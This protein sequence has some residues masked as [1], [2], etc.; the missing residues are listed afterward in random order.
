[1]SPKKRPLRKSTFPSL[2]SDAPAP[3]E[4][5]EE[6]TM[7]PSHEI[8]T[9]QRI[10]ADL[11]RKA[12]VGKITVAH[13]K[14]VKSLIDKHAFSGGAPLPFTDTARKHFANFLEKNRNMHAATSGSAATS[15]AV[16]PVSIFDS[17]GTD[18]TARMAL[19]LKN[20][21]T[22]PQTTGREEIIAALTTTLQRSGKGNAILTGDAGVGKSAIVEALALRTAKGELRG[23]L[24]RAR[25]VELA[26]CQLV[27]LVQEGSL[28]EKLRRLLKECAAI[29]NVILFIDE[30]HVVMK[31]PGMADFL[32][33]EIARGGVHLIGATTRREF[34]EMVRE[35]AALERRFAIIDVPE[36][37]E[38]ASIEALK[39]NVGRYEAHHGLRIEPEAIIEAV[40]MSA[41]YI[42]TRR[43][44]DKA[45]DVLDTAC[46]RN[47]LDG[48]DTVTVD[49]I[50][51][52]V[53]DL[54][55]IS[56][57]GR[58]DSRA[59]MRT[60]E[61]T[62][63]ERIIGQDEAISSVC[64]VF[65]LRETDMAPTNKPAS[66]L[67]A[68]PTGVGKTETAKATASAIFG[69][70][71]SFI[72]LDMTEYKNPSS[73][74][75]LI[76]AS[77]GLVGAE[78]GGLLTER[79]RTRPDSLILVDELDKANEDVQL[80]F[81]QLLEEGRL[82]DGRGETVNCANAVVV[83]TTNAGFTA[84]GAIGTKQAAMG[85]NSGP[86]TALDDPE[87]KARLFLKKFFPPEILNRFDNIVLFNQL[88]EQEMGGIA[89]LRIAEAVQAAEKRGYAVTV[90]EDVRNLVLERSDITHYGA[91]V[92]ARTV[93]KLVKLP[94]ARFMHSDDGVKE[95]R[96]ALSVTDKEMTVHA[97]NAPKP[98]PGRM[99]SQ[100]NP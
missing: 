60:L 58:E 2:R 18:L 7:I 82:T 16:T 90:G 56:L 33:P 78:R 35:D 74:S 36:L 75:R 68:G 38:E 83:M 99:T 27:T 98:P 72:T 86:K 52:C 34:R 77:V 54:T 45:F 55:H 93:R 53:S 84:E 1:M 63:R 40:R 49:D 69:D 6:N 19:K 80:V 48:R 5:M 44:P 25:I 12:G 79:L 31:I 37:S 26:S 21:E 42:T 50:R 47:V 43:L 3:P 65:A 100:G 81:M 13:I 23:R 51:N 46:S 71:D 24:N 29:G 59:R 66:L 17:F 20:G 94:I 14:K 30:F 8:L 89:D 87:D 28:A 62:L 15:A 22:L 88:G 96:F 9:I 10:A 76:G 70:K 4:N 67:F 95:R 91:R 32:K 64:D 97:V 92:I 41:R 39:A 61:N 85:F 11:A 57:A 73:L